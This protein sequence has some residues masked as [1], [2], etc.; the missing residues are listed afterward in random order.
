MK[1]LKVEKRTKIYKKD[2][3]TSK[4]NE[5]SEK[6]NHFIEIKKVTATI[7]DVVVNSNLLD[8]VVVDYTDDIDRL[9][10]FSGIEDINSIKEIAYTIYWILRHKPIQTKDCTENNFAV[11]NINEEFC[12]KYLCDYLSV[13]IK[14]IPGR[15]DRKHIFER[16]EQMEVFISQFL[17]FFSYRTYTAQSIELC[18]ISFLSGQIYENTDD[19]LLDF[20]HPIDCEE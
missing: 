3:F 17:Y 14:A 6:L 20:L 18:I 2:E 4:F 5:L 13:P 16:K 19:N 12:V 11:R 10:E 8:C 7:T 1:N 15:K 9:K